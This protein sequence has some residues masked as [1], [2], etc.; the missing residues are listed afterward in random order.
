MVR[1][2]LTWPPLAPPT[3]F[4]LLRRVRYCGGVV[5]CVHDDLN[6]CC[7]VSRCCP[8]PT[9][10]NLDGVFTQLSPTL[11]I[12]ATST[13]FVWDGATFTMS[14][15]PDEPNN[16][17][18]RWI[19][20]VPVNEFETCDFQCEIDCLDTVPPTYVMTILGDSPGWEATNG[21]GPEVIAIR[22]ICC[23]DPGSFL[24]EFRVSVVNELACCNTE[25]STNY[26]F[27][28]I[29]TGTCPSPTPFI[30]PPEPIRKPVRRKPAVDPSLPG[31]VKEW[32]ANG[33]SN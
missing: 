9:P 11:P 10:N 30:E 20:D 17:A 15:D 2:L 33:A 29:L 31:D 26:L 21:G 5:R 25:D 22:T 13:A 28:I 6:C 27:S 32:L 8:C 14:K 16:C 7:N 1:Q 3:R 23:H 4:N 12:C 24:L 18:Q 19:I